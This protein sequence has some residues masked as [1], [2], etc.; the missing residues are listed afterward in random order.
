MSALT[1]FAGTTTAALAMLCITRS[2]AADGGSDPLVAQGLFEAGLRLMDTGDYAAACP[3]LEESQRLDPGG[4]T[5]LNIA[6]CHE[7]A[8]HLATAMLEYDRALAQALRDKH[9]NRET[10]A[11]ER[12]AAI[13]PLVPRLTVTLGPL[14]PRDAIVRLDDSQVARGA[15]DVALPLNAGKHVVTA[16]A[17]GYVT[18]TDEFSIREGEQHQITITEL[19]RPKPG[20]NG[21]VLPLPL[22]PPRSHPLVPALWITGGVSLLVTG[23]TGVWSL[24][25]YTQYKTDCV[26]GRSFCRTE[27]GRDAAT[28]ARTLAVVS[29]ISLGVAAAAL[30]TIPLLPNRRTGQ[31]EVQAGVDHWAIAGT[32]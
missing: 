24:V 8:G 25:S 6:L 2:A 5:L 7:R 17:P 16:T 21:V 23:V 14:V 18:R 3:K 15:L 28:R 32:F 19:N 11:R 9:V 10:F 12:L 22:P 20:P 30:I 29:T 1:R 26:E 13:T 27:A 4:G 31:L